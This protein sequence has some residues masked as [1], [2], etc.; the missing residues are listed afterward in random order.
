M[1]NANKDILFCKIQ[2]FLWAKNL[3]LEKG[4]WKW[5]QQVWSGFFSLPAMFDI[6]F[7]LSNSAGHNQGI[8]DGIVVLTNTNIYLLMSSV[9]FC[10]LKV[11]KFLKYSNPKVLYPRYEIHSL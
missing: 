9:H 2:L 6:F 10:I 3:R 11:D 8:E 4:V 7:W 5:E 1:P